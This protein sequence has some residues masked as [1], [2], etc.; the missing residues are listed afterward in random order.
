MV[1]SNA[2]LTLRDVVFEKGRWGTLLEQEVH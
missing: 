1:I 2:C